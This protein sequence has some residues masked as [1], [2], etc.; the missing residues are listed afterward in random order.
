MNDADV[1]CMELESLRQVLEAWSSSSKVGQCTSRL[2]RRLVQRAAFH[3]LHEEPCS[4]GEGVVTIV[5]SSQILAI[6]VDTAEGKTG[7]C[8]ATYGEGL[9]W[10]R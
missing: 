1:A 3:P 6:I 2:W 7:R 5:T 9:D 4:E 8:N 10:L